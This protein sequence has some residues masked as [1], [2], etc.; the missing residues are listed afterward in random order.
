MDRPGL[1]LAF[2]LGRLSATTFDPEVV[3]RHAE[4]AGLDGGWVREVLAGDACAVQADRRGAERLG[5]SGEAGEV[6]A[7]GSR[8]VLLR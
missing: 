6:T 3:V 2:S 4:A 5:L 1:P 8:P 7:S